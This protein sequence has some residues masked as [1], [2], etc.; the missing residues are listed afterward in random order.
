MSQTSQQSQ[1]RAQKRSI[2][3]SEYVINENTNS[4]LRNCTHFSYKHK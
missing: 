3:A 1:I 4:I 2:E